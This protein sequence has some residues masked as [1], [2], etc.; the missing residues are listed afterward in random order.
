M[1]LIEADC[2]ASL[3]ACTAPFTPFFDFTVQRLEDDGT[4]RPGHPGLGAAGT[5]VA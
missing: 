5:L 4:A 1:G 3:T 2:P